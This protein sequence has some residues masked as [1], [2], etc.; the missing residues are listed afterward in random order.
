MQYAG[1]T[2]VGAPFRTIVDHGI[3]V[4]IHGDGA[5][6]APLSPWPHIYYATTGVS[7]FGEQVNPG[8]HLTRREALRLFTRGNAWF[9]RM[10]DKIGSI[11]PG[12]LADLLVLNRDY[13]TV[14]DQDIKKIRP[15]LTMV[16]GTV[17]HDTGELGDHRGRRRDTRGHGDPQGRWD[18]ESY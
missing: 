5:H 11:E 2:N 6:I 18:R 1:A 7:S 13:F 8:Q 15:I 9:L 12:K 3:Q 16:D 17:V 4:G 14:P 10:E